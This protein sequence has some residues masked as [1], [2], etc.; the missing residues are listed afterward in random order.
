MIRDAFTK[1]SYSVEQ[2]KWRQNKF[3]GRFKTRHDSPLCQSGVDGNRKMRLYVGNSVRIRFSKRNIKTSKKTFTFSGRAIRQVRVPFADLRTTNGHSGCDIH[4]ELHLCVLSVWKTYSDDCISVC[5]LSHSVVS[6]SFATP[7]TE[8]HQDPLSM[9]FSR[10]EYQSGFQF[11][12][13]GDLP[14]SGDKPASPALPGR[15]FTN[16]P[17][18]KP[19]SQQLDIKL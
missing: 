14:D 7:W 5:V 16:E 11:P 13:P 19:S 18:G 17:L 8:S 9:K 2:I 1:I 15:F 10:Q 3:Q 4:Q 6:D 12:T